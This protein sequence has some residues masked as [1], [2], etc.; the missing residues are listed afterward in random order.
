MIYDT[1][2]D[3]PSCDIIGKLKVVEDKTQN[4]FQEG[5]ETSISNTL[6]VFH[7]TVL[8]AEDVIYQQG[9]TTILE[10]NNGSILR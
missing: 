9:T 5:D 2:T 7:V 4:I 6:N 8:N 3:I 1:I 10:G